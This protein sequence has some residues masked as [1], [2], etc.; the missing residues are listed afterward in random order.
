MGDQI[1]RVMS[2]RSEYKTVYEDISLNEDAN[3]GS[4]SRSGSTPINHKEEPWSDELENLVFQWR[5]HVIDQ[6]NMHDEAGYRVKAK[7]HIIGF[8]TI[9]IPL[10]M[11]IAQTY[12]GGM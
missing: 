5:Q 11:T 6:H 2:N 8:P 10:C 7:H 9:L 1:E 3:N 4:E 12:I